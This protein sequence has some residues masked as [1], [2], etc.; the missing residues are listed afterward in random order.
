MSLLNQINN[1]N[2]QL[3]L[4]LKFWK[5]KCLKSYDFLLLNSEWDKLAIV[6]L[7]LQLALILERAAEKLS[8]AFKRLRKSFS[9]ALLFLIWSKIMFWAKDR[10]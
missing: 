9:D 2:Y 8:E 1:G 10:T 4:L 7:K 3:L 6:K 5:L